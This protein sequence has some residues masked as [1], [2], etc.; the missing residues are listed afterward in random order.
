MVRPPSDAPQPQDL[1]SGDEAE[2]ESSEDPEASPALPSATLVAHASALRRERRRRTDREILDLA[3]PVILSQI[4]ASAVSLIDIA[5]LGR[6]GPNSLAAVG[7]A[8]QFFWLSQA[9]LF[10]I[11]AACVAVMAQALGAGEPIRARVAL[12]GSVTLALLISAVV[13][14][15]VLLFPR[16]LLDL[17]NAEPD[18][19]EV[20]LPYLRLTLAS[21]VLFAVSITVE[22][23][24]RAAKDTRTPLWI[25]GGVTVLKIVLNGALIFG[26][27]GGPRLGLAGAGLATLL[28]QA[29]AVVLLVVASRRGPSSA[30]RGLYL[31]DLGRMRRSLGEVMRLAAPAVGERLVLNAALMTYFAFLGH[32]GSAALAAY[33]VGVRVLSF[34]WIPGTGF[35]AA[36]A[37]LVGHAVGA[38]DARGA[39]RAGWRAA[40]L[41]LVVSGA[42]GILYAFA[43]SPLARL[44]TD[45]PGVIEQL[46]PFMLCLAL[47]QPF[48]GLHFTLGGALRGAGDTLS[49]LLAATLGNWAFR[50]PLAYLAAMVFATDVIWVWAALVVDHLAR[51]IWLVIAFGRG[52]WQ[53]RVAATP[54]A[55]P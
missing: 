53:H 44:F 16:P 2:I 3:W 48:L 11:G 20:T 42:V 12:A 34:S 50:V 15:L 49:P 43:R 8:T 25:A 35:A 4:L 41:S 28:S 10:A 33:T 27:L 29:V 36:A 5:M 9:I 37:T 45:D 13:A 38:G 24:F 31:R 19:V 32:Y 7:Y 14:A 55:A 1:L 26:W 22:S 46:G 17:L 23:G 39:A 54:G 40:R 47:A 30:A 51:A 18:V 52:R 6:L 21:T